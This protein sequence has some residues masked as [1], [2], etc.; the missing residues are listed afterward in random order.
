MDVTRNPF[1]FGD[2]ALDDGFADRDAELAEVVADIRNGQNLVVFAPRRYG[3]SSLVWRAA[4]QLV[5]KNEALVAQVDLMRTTTKEQLAAAL[6]K[7]IYD[8]I[9]TPLF[10]ARERAEKIFGGL[11]IAPVMTVDPSG[12]LGFS[13]RA[14][15]VQA[16][17]DAT[18]ESLLELPAQL[19]AD[20]RKR[21]ALVLDE[22]QEI[23]ALDPHLPSLMRSVFQTQPDVSHVYLGSKHTMMERLFGDANEPFWRSAKRMELDVIPRDA[24]APFLVERF[25]ATNRRLPPEIAEGVLAITGGHPYATQEL[26]Y[27]LWEET[28]RSRAACAESLA[29]ALDRVLRS[30]NAHFSLVWEN[31]SQGQRLVLQALAVESTSSVLA[32]EYRRRHDL[33]GASSVQRAVTKLIADELVERDRAG[34]YRIMEP[35]LAE[36]LARRLS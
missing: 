16:D 14:G 8:E 25:A 26:C 22:F 27:A 13:F 18:L 31:A 17:V 7:A 29:R 36:W 9:A 32:R 34:E 24:F 1:N 3:K 10:R 35:F 12:G 33:P 11:R 5:A 19:A 23:L 2:L 15:H 21:V 6:A 28:P 30:E 4:Q 20:R